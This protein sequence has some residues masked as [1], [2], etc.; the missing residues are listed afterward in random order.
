MKFSPMVDRVVRD[1]V[2]LLQDRPRPA[3]TTSVVRPIEAPSG[4]CTTTKKAPWSSSGRKPVGVILPS[5]PDASHRNTDHHQA[6]DGNAHEPR[7]DG[8]IGVAHPVD[9]AH[10]RADR[11]AA[12]AMV[13]PQQ[14]GAQCRRQ[15]QRID[16]RQEHRHGDRHRELPEQLARDARDEGHR[17]EHRQQHKRDGDDRRGDLSHRQLGRLAGDSSGW[18]S[19]TCSTA[20]T[21]TIASSTTMPMASTIASRET[22]LAE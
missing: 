13:R 22:V 1:G 8:A 18:C 7:D 14:H 16:R 10:Q 5:P 15:R 11:S 21:T 3:A 12:R 17:H 19:I 2:F 20:S 4:N 9:A 6:D